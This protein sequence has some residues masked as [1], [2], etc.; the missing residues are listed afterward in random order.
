M[1]SYKFRSYLIRVSQL[2]K[3]C[4]GT[5]RRFLFYNVASIVFHHQTRVYR[6]IIKYCNVHYKISICLNHGKVLIFYKV[7]YT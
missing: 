6:N 4:E 5:L 3:W 7:S 1:L 2:L